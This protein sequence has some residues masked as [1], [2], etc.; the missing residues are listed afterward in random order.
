MYYSTYASVRG[1]GNDELLLNAQRFSLWEDVQALNVDGGDDDT[2]AWKHLISVS[3]T[4]KFVKME[5]F[6]SCVIYHNKKGKEKKI[7]A[8]I[9]FRFE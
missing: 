1:W 7:F 5:T 3:Y 4:L 2:T 9:S 8:L 6:M